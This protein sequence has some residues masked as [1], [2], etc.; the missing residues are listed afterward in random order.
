MA[1]LD[2]PPVQLTFLAI[3]GRGALVGQHVCE[4]AVNQIGERVTLG[5]SSLEA[6]TFNDCP[7]SDLRPFAGVGT[8]FSALRA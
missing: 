1:Q 3:D 4:V 7:F 5:L 6:S 2:F 8:L